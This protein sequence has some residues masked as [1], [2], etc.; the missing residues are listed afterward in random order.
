MSQDH[1]MSAVSVEAAFRQAMR[2]F[3]STVTV[4]TGGNAAKLFK[5]KVPKAKKI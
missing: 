4:I 1:N 5:I 2:G 3:A